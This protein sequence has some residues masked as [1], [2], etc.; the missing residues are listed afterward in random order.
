MPLVEEILEEIKGVGQEAIFFNV[1]AADP[2][3]RKEVLDKVE[4]FLLKEPETR[5]F[6]KVFVHSLAFGTLRP[7]IGEDFQN[8]ITKA[9]L[10]MTLD[11]MANSFVYWVQDMVFRRLLSEGSC[12][13]ALTSAGSH[14]VWHSYGAISGAKAALEAYVRQLAVELAPY[15]IRVNAIQPGITDTPALRKIPGWEKLKE[16]ALKRNPFRR[17]TKP[18]DVA[19]IV[20][21]LAK[22]ETYWITGNVIGADGGEDIV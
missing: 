3:R 16:E 5:R 12:V 22:S 11:V 13:F 10:E 6:V 21:A 17:L 15:K 19:E 1:N 9:Q 2:Q 8:S 20:V 4:G 18:E 14:R 7:F